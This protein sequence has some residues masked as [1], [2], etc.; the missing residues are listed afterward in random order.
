MRAETLDD[1]Q[2]WQRAKGLVEAV[3]AVTGGGRVGRNDRLRS[4]IDDAVDS[5]LSNIAEGFGQATDRAFARYLYIARGS[6]NEASS[7]LAVAAARGLV[8]QATAASLTQE[9]TEIARMLSGLIRYLLRSD[10]KDRF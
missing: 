9:A 2:V 8:D 7:H 4:Q 10:W 6:A 1:L 3:S 5:V